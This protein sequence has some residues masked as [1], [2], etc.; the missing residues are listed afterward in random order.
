ME[1]PSSLNPEAIR[2]DVAK[3]SKRSSLSLKGE[4]A[5]VVRGVYTEGLVSGEKAIGY[6]NEEGIPE[7]SFTETYAALCLHIEN[8]RWKGYLFTFDR[9]KGSPVKPAR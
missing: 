3:G 7:D 8:W 5:E 2:D 9:G 1:P 4:N 6:L